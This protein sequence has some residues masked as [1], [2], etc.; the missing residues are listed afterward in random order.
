MKILFAL[1]I[2]IYS[3]T[4]LSSQ[5]Q[6]GSPAPDF[7]VQDING[8]TF[9]LYAMMGANKAACLDFMAT[10]CGPCWSFKTSGVLEQVYNNLSSQTTAIM[11]EA[12]WSTNT[13][14]LYGPSGCNSTTQGNWVAGTPYQ[15]A[16]LSSTNGPGVKSEYAISYYPTLYVI[17][18][19]KRCWEITSRTYQNYNNWITK[20]FALNATAS[21]TNST[22]GDNGKIILNPVGGYSNLSYKWSN[23]A[24]TKDLNN[25]PG[26]NYSVTITDL[27]SYFK[28]FGPFEVVGPQ[29]RVA[30]TNSHLNHVNCFGEDNGN[31]E[32][33]VEYGTAPYT[34]QWSNGT[35][36]KL[37][38]N[39]IAGSYTV[40]V[41]DY[42]NCSALRN[43]TITQ[44][45]KVK[46]S[47]SP[48]IETCNQE[49]GSILAKGSGGIFPYTYDIGFGPQTNPF[50]SGLTGDQEYTIIMHDAHNC[51]ESAT[52]FLDKTSKPFASAGTNK[53]LNCKPDFVILDG[54]QSE[55]SP[56]IVYEWTTKSGNIKSGGDT[57]FPS[58]DA[59][60]TYTLKVKDILTKCEDSDSV[61]VVDIRVYPP[62][63][64]SGDTAIDC[65]NTQVELTGSST[66]TLVLFYWTKKGDTSFLN[67]NKVLMVDKDGDYILNV[68]DT[69]NY[70]LSKDTSIVTLDQNKP[71][72]VANPEKELSCKTTEIIID[73][74]ASSTGP[75]F[76]YLWTT[77]DGQIAS[78]D[79]SLTPVVVKA[80]SYKLE[81]TNTINHCTGETIALVLQQTTPLADF[82][83]SVD[84]LTIELM[85]LSKGLPTDRL[86]NFGDG[87][88]STL[89]NP[90]H[91]YA[92]KGEY[93]VCLQATND[94]GENTVCKN[95][96]VGIE[97][98]LSLVSWEIRNA[99][100]YQSSDGHIILNVSGGV[101]PY[102]Y[103][104]NT[105]ETNKDLLNIPAGEYTVE[106]TDAQGTRINRMFLIKEPTPIQLADSIITAS[107]AGESKGSIELDI[108]GGTP[109]YS[110]EWN[111]GQSS[112]PAVNLKAGFYTCIV[113]DDA[114]CERQFGPFEVKEIVG[115][116]EITGLKQ[117]LVYPN[118]ARS[119]F[120]I[121][122]EFAQYQSAHLKILDVYGRQIWSK[123]FQNK[124]FKES[125]I[126]SDLE[127]GV[128]IIYLETSEAVM[129]HRLIID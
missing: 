5:L 87:S 30:I 105:Q 78:G 82:E 58:V 12:D 19:D 61:N 81:V 52:I 77:A 7:T 15:I 29:K 72:A 45:T 49:N 20:S 9:S 120:N 10:W 59:P 98:P 55:Q 18:P 111:D 37:N 4:N 32:I 41:L 86:W 1:I 97:K 125:I 33:E 91:T 96:L 67:N 118:P 101:P 79:T 110:F 31:I 22:C 62:L 75:Q 127:A 115:N 68:L 65:K 107:P 112:N 84:Q 100:C 80:G 89:I 83:N 99:K 124:L 103:M 85:D 2:L 94:C 92:Q 90:T 129:G 53:D 104:W 13:S 16:D 26:G 102:S 38:P 17:S 106:I 64:V 27:N 51:E 36:S 11:I 71:E 122:I 24:T 3:S 76:K 93:S 48:A 8:N 56:S 47:L 95:I 113:K 63:N 50:F 70:C 40:T 43:Y 69:F 34:Y 128:Y 117:F 21:I 23:G 46:L 121:E 108:K 114:D 119:A 42:N 28:A 6:N 57:Q 44:P 60:G 88:T 116:K 35:S 54:G 109:G 126:G 74:S 25:L 14:C 39:L 66:D 123:T 73:G